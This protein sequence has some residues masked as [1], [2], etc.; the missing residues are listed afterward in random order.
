MKGRHGRGCEDRETTLLWSTVPKDKGHM[1][2][3]WVCFDGLGTA[4]CAHLLIYVKPPTPALA[5][6]AKNLRL[7]F[8][9]CF[10]VRTDGAWPWNRFWHGFGSPLISAANGSVAVPSASSCKPGLALV[11]T[12]PVSAFIRT[13]LAEKRCKQ[14]GRLSR[15]CRDSER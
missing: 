11:R 2:R 8:L 15:L 14:L 9:A 5:C 3:P 10:S 4:S 1:A 12:L 6:K 7:G 13:C